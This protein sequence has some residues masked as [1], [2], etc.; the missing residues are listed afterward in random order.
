MT[1]SLEAEFDSGSAVALYT[2]HSALTLPVLN[3][4]S[5]AEETR[6]W[7]CLSL[8]VTDPYLDK[9]KLDT[10]VLYL[11]HQQLQ[12]GL[13]GN[14]DHIGAVN[15]LPV[16]REATELAQ[17]VS[18]PHFPLGKPRPREG[19]IGRR[20]CGKEEQAG[21]Q[22]PG[23]HIPHSLVL[24]AEARAGAVDV[25]TGAAMVQQAGEGGAGGE[26]HCMDDRA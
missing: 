26:G 8:P 6:V 16:K 4:G 25:I 21:P 17:G 22:G 9:D 20:E 3:L 23:Q 7:N 19:P 14:A 11:I 10:R 24:E 5:Q 18:K 13:D 2:L 15:G 1:S 12:V